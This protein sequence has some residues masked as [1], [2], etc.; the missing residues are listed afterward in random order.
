M[1]QIIFGSNTAYAVK[2][3]PEPAQW[4]AVARDAGLSNV[5]FSFDL[6]DPLMAER[7]PG[8]WDEIRFAADQHGLT[9]TSAFTGL[10]AYSQNLLGHPDDG[11]RERAEEWYRLALA[12]AA[13]IGAEGAGG[14]VGTISVAQ[15]ATPADRAKAI[16]RII[17][18]MLRLAEVGRREGL[19]FLLWELMPVAR[20]YPARIEEVEEMLERVR[21]AAIPI[22]LCL[23]LGH[24]CLAGASAEDRNPYN[25]LGRVGSAAHTIHLQQTDGEGDRHW[26]FTAE[27]NARGIIDA[28]RVMEIVRTLPQERVELMLEFI[29][30]FEAPDTQV[31]EDLRASV[32]YWRPWLGCNG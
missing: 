17:D 19:R 7:D 20:E 16:S 3:W 28:G 4:A 30:A 13:R 21:D 32:A 8:T 11:Q 24:T 31:T 14:H 10:I 9:I 5:Q 12:A 1:P 25:W 2:R 29:H 6:L 26:P 23:D 27:F 22:R 15:A 18:A